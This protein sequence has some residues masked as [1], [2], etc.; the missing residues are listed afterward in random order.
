MERQG[1]FASRVAAK[2]ELDEGKVQDAFKQVA[3]EVED[4]VLQRK[5]GRMVERRRL[6]E[7]QADEY[8]KWY[9]SRPEG[10]PS[11]F[12]FRG[13]FGG[14]MWGGGGWRGKEHHDEGQ[15]PS[16]GPES[17]ESASR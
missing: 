17:P 16:H 12:A 3:R 10:L 2:L 11:R 5:L 6:T 13:P 8:R 9:R 14:G 15:G 4:E 7:E 1:R